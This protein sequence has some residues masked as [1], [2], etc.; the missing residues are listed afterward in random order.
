MI[1]ELGNFCLSLALVIS[2]AQAVLPLVGAQHQKHS[3]MAFARPAAYTQWLI[4]ALAYALLTYA[5]ITHDYSILYVANNSNNVQ[6]LMY[7]ISGVWGAHEG[8]LLLWILMLSSWTALVGLFSRGVPNDMVARVLGVLGLVSIGFLSFTLLTSNPFERLLTVPLD[9]R[10]LN[11]LLQDPGLIIHPPML[12]MGYVGTSVVFAFAIAAMLSGKLD[13][14]WAR[15][16]RPWTTISWVFLTIGI[17]LG[18]WWAYYELGWGGWWFWDPV[19]NAS[20]MPWLVGTALIHSLAVTEKRGALKAWT[21]LLAILA[22][23]LSLLGTFLVRS[24]VL[25]SVHSFASDP[26]RGLFIL[27]FLLIVIGGSLL[28]YAI[29]APKMI[30]DVGFGLF[31][32]ETMILLNNILLL[33]A[34]AMVLFGTLYPLVIDAITGNK[35]SVGPPYFDFMFVVLTLPLAV[36]VG[37]GAMSRWKRDEISRFLPLIGSFVVISLLISAVVTNILSIERFSYGA[38]AGI[39][40]AC[41]VAV[42]ALY[43]LYDRVK[44]QKSKLHGLSKIPASI[45]GMSI[46]HFG[47]AIFIVGVTHVNSYSVEKDI[48]MNPGES[49]QVGQYNFTF[50]GVSRVSEANYLANEGTFTISEENSNALLQLKPQKRF[51]SSNN[52]MTEAAIDSTLGRD[53]FISLGED[54]GNGAWSVRIY[55]K[56]FVAC[57]WLGGFFMALGG[58]FATMDRRYRRPIKKTKPYDKNAQVSNA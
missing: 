41:W 7:R 36:I 6:P 24:G 11:P 39:A 49:Y 58:L 32:K 22:F 40:L 9:G 8:S 13:T 44:H 19:E 25:T 30:S 21:I 28:L 18:S 35:I 34:T 27:I 31:S 17:T 43:G 51:Y 2:I 47:V 50:D 55:L 38:F 26:E 12:Y 42:W 45:W 15:W 1:A 52:A 16:A 48:R 53:L 20:F 54:L 33:V 4:V 14:A 57:I 37:V 56:S 10:E 23:S 5:F 3:W 29:R 46:A